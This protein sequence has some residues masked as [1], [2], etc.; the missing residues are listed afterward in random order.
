[1]P[2]V[3]DSVGEITIKLWSKGISFCDDCI[4]LLV[5][6]LDC[7]IGIAGRFSF[8]EKKARFRVPLMIK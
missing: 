8:P 2:G 5:D 4:G 3:L 7:T 6:N 1:M